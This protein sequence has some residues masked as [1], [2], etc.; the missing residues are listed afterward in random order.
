VNDQLAV[1]AAF[2]VVC[3]PLACLIVRR[4]V[5]PAEAVPSRG[6]HRAPWWRPLPVTGWCWAEDRDTPQ[7]RMGAADELVCKLCGHIVPGDGR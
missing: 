6:R 3:L 4:L 5:Q 2:L 1:G 7:A